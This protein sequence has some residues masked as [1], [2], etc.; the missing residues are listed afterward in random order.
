MYKLW[1]LCT[2]EATDSISGWIKLELYC[3][4]KISFCNF[5][6]HPFLLLTTSPL[7]TLLLHQWCTDL[8]YGKNGK[9][10]VLFFYR[11]HILLSEMQGQSASIDSR[12]I[13]QY[14]SILTRVSYLYFKQYRF[15]DIF[16]SGLIVFAIMELDIQ[17]MTTTEQS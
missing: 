13:H 10:T 1:I 12:N 11:D 3:I 7:H 9:V 6:N 17:S 8:A 5:K 16:P 14:F 2:N 15:I 4:P